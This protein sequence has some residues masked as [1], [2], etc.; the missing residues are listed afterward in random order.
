MYFVNKCS[1]CGYQTPETQDM[2]CPVCSDRKNRNYV[3]L[4]QWVRVESN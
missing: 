2:F 3:R 1:Q 4:E